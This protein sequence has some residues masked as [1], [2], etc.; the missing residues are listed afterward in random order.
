LA[1]AL[2]FVAAAGAAIGIRHALDAA[3]LS[4]I[5]AATVTVGRVAALD[6]AAAAV[7]GWGARFAAVVVA[8]AL[9]AQIELART[10]AHRLPGAVARIATRERAG[11]EH[12]IAPLAARAIA[13]AA[14]LDAH[15]T[16]AGRFA[17]TRA[18]VV[19]QTL[20][21]GARGTERTFARALG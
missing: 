19:H 5:A 13:G 15:V 12:G 21:T 8:E 9:H 18:L 14:T 17:A 10:A 4:G 3:A 16:D 6:A 7:A 11:Q 20:A 1:A 2:A